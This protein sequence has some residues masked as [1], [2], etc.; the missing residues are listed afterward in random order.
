MMIGCLAPLILGFLPRPTFDA[1]YAAGPDVI[2]AGT[3]NPKGV[4]TPVDGG[5][6]VSGQWPFASGCQH[7]DWIIAHCFVDDGRQPPL[8]MMVLPPDEVEIKDTWWV[9]GL[10]G[11]GSHDFLVD[12]AFVPDD[13]SFSILEPQ[14]GVEGPLWRIPE[15]SSTTLMTAAV[16][17]GI[18]Q[19][20]LDDIVALAT[21]KVPAF[22]DSTLAT[23]PLFQNQ[24]GEAD[25]TLRAVEA[26]LDA[27]AEEAWAV[28]TT[29]SPF[30]DE[31]RARVRGTTTWVTRT[32]AS[33]V[34]VAY[35]A[36]GGSSL[37][38]SNPLQ[39]RLRDVRA[40]TQHFS[41]KPD[42]FTLV[43]AVLTGQAADTSFL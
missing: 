31:H 20:A 38:A 35:S 32:A 14:P 17:V 26:A 15:L 29:G 27:E 11:T 40:L 36:G 33:I 6:R 25:A 10:C 43:G 4:A 21:D 8:R 24:L 30:S 41:M 13:H 1:M 22:T 19:G 34:D 7:A 3:F 16:A 12:G 9:S 5:F 37:Y 28:G 2:V 39:R 18:A 42:V 23:N